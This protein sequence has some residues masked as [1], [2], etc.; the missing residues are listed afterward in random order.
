VSEAWQTKS[1]GEVCEVVA[2]QSPQ[3]RYYNSEGEGLPFYQG[4]KEF[5]EKFLGAPTTWTTQAT[6]RATSGDVLMSV[7]A[8]VGPVNFATEDICIGRGLAAIR[9]SHAL[10]RDFLFYALLNLQPRIAGREG[11]VF[12]SI[13]KPEI[14]KL[15]I[16]VPSLRAQQRIVGLLDEAFAG[17]ATAKANAEKNLQ[18]ARELFESCLQAVFT[19]E[20]AEWTKMR[21]EEI[22]IDFG[23]GR[24]RHRPRNAKHLY[25]GKYP[26]VQTGNI[27]GASHTITEYSQTYNEAGLAQSKLWPRGT[28]CIT[29]AANI[30]ETAILGFDACFPDSVIGLVPDPKKANSDYIEFLLRSLKAHLQKMGQGS[31]QANINLGTFENERF[32]F[33]PV[34]EQKKLAASLEELSA[35]IQLLEGLYRRKLVAL[36]GLKSSLL[37]Q[38]FRGEL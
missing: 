9:S 4:K 10:N 18:N 28:I 13:S 38:A 24:S 37:H 16:P 27:R 6:K 19:P 34:A 8:P 20:R 3:G 7:R 30:A 33:P 22:A 21:L 11:A 14:E 35:E 36:E 1:L 25:G 17:L 15:R 31:A 5:G 29:I 12:A 32:P 2:G 26:F 23:R